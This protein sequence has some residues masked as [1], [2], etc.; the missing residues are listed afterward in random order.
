MLI[1]PESVRE[2]D[3]ACIQSGIPGFRLMT[4]AG[5]AVAASALRHFPGARRFAVLAGPGNNGGD[6]YIAAGA[7][8]NAGAEIEVFQLPSRRPSTDDAARALAECGV[9]AQSMNAFESTE[10]DI[11]IDGVF[12]AGLSRDVPSELAT[13]IAK[14]KLLR[15]PVLAVDLPSGIDGRT[16]QVLGAAFKADVTVTFMA[17][18]PGMLLLPGREHC[19]Q[20]EIAEIGVPKRLIEAHRST[21]H[22]NGPEIWHAYP[23]PRDASAH[24]YSRGAL[25]VFSGGASHTGAARLT[26]NAGLKAGA[27]LVTIASPAEAMEVNATHLTAVMLRQIDHID[28][29]NGWLE[30]KRLSTFVLGPGFGVGAKA[31]DFVLALKDRK[32]VLDAD[33]ITSFRDD[34]S[35]L[36]NAFAT[37]EPHLILTPHEGEFSRLFAD[38]AGDARLS[39]VDKAIA[40]ARRANAAVIYKGSDTVIASADGR[41]AINTNAPPSLATAGSGDV[42]AGICGALLAQGYPAYEAACAAVWH[43][44]DAANRAGAGLTAET[45][46]ERVRR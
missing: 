28:D 25:A 39:K 17:L 14:I 45:L 29:L 24:K 13:L 40:A 16:G 20:V 11:V 42:L 19:G 10:G 43:H 41:A 12:G 38:I 33:G 2:I 5:L 35:I 3:A 15:I 44:G 7:L 4:A 1:E 36:F 6:A 46:V 34:P 26:A 30:D 8:R 9:V 32:L 23:H 22:V 27:G 18:K 21:V 31:R 37:G